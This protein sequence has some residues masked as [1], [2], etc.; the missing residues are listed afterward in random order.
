MS[1]IGNNKDSLQKRRETQNMGV[2]DKKYRVW[3]NGTVVYQSNNRLLALGYINDN[4]GGTFQQAMKTGGY[5]FE[6]DGK[7]IFGTDLKR[8]PMMRL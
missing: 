1:D 2:H 4:F 8:Q 6:I 7:L 3:K 5:G